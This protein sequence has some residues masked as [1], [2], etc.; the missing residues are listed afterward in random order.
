M[1]RKFRAGEHTCFC[2]AYSFPHRFGGGRC[3]GQN[4]VDDQW[5]Y[6]FGQGAC[7]PCVAREDQ[8]CDV[9]DG[10]EKVTVCPVWQDFVR[11][12]EIRLLGPYWAGTKL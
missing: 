10:R 6:N 8:T 5:L 1:A 3:R 9:F 12:Y 2:Y 7:E 11:D 4:I